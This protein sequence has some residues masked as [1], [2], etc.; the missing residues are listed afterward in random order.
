MKIAIYNDIG[1]APAVTCLVQSLEKL[2]Y[3]PTFINAEHLINKGLMD[4]TVLFF[5]G[6]ADQFYCQKLNGAGTTHI[7]DW[8]FKG[9]TYIGI[10]AGAYFGSGFCEF[11]KNGPQEIVGK[12]ELA[13]FPGTTVGP[14]YGEYTY[15]GHISA[16]AV[17]IDYNQK[18]FPV[19]YNGGCLFKDAEKREGVKILGRFSDTSM[20]AIIEI[21][22]GKGKAILS[23][24][25]FEITTQYLKSAIANSPEEQ[26]NIEEIISAL[27]EN[28][29][30]FILQ[31]L[32]GKIE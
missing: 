15:A 29:T 25:H 27:R 6:G 4:A 5:P 21:P 32:L 30:L 11:D 14:L 13:F 26:I 9:G 8:V 3:T 1:V 22:Y 7:K 20:P 16:K 10:C 31:D 23:G 17:S 28:D 19:Y 12:R 18:T 2:A 24:I